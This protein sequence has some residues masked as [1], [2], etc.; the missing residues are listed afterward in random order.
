MTE[1]YEIL[2]NGST[3]TNQTISFKVERN[4]NERSYLNL[5][6]INDPEISVVEGDTINVKV[7]SHS[8]TLT[9][10]FQGKVIKTSKGTQDGDPIL[11]VDGVDLLDRLDELN[12][13]KTYTNETGKTICLD[14]LSE[15]PEITTSNVGD[16]TIPLDFTSRGKTRLE[17]IKDLGFRV[18]WDWY[19]DT[20]NDFHFFERNSID[21]GKTIRL[22]DLENYSYKKDRSSIINRI[23]VLGAEYTIPDPP[24][25]WSD[26]LDDWEGAP[27]TP[28]LVGQM[29]DFPPRL[30]KYAISEQVTSPNTFCYLRRSFSS[31]DLSK[32]WSPKTLNID[33]GFKTEVDV[34]NV[35]LILEEDSSNYFYREITS[36]FDPKGGAWR[37]F[38]VSVGPESSWDSTGNPSWTNINAIKVLLKFVSSTALLFIDRVYFSGARYHGF[39]EDSGPGSSQEEWGVCEPPH[40]VK[41]NI[42]SDSECQ[43]LADKIIEENKEPKEII[44]DTTL[45]PGW[46]DLELGSKV[47]LE[48]PEGTFTKRIL[49]LVHNYQDGDFYTDLTLSKK[50]RTLSEILQEYDQ[51]LKQ[52]SA[53]KEEYKLGA[54]EPNA[55]SRQPCSD[56]CQTECQTDCQISCEA[57]D[58]TCASSYN[59]QSSCQQT[60]QGVKACET[61]G[62][63]QSACQAGHTCEDACQ[64]SCQSTCQTACQDT[65]GCQTVCQE[66]SQTCAS[67]GNCQESCQLTCQGSKACETSGVCQTACQ[68]GHTCEATCQ[69]ACQDTGGCQTECQV[70]CQ[71]ECQPT[72]QTECQDSAGCQTAC[73]NTDQTCGISGNCQVTCQQTCQGSKACE[74]A[75]VCQTACETGHTCQ[76]TCQT[77]C[78]DTVGCQ[79]ECQQTSQTC[80]SSGNCQVACQ[81]TFQG[82]SNYMDKTQVAAATSYNVNATDSGVLAINTTLS[83]VPSDAIQLGAYYLDI[84]GV[85]SGEWARLRFSAEIVKPGGGVRARLSDEFALVDGAPGDT[86]K[87]VYWSFKRVVYLEEIPQNGDYLKLWIYANHGEYKHLDVSVYFYVFRK[88][89]H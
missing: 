73:Q 33:I 63:C 71:V 82:T 17:A 58:Q 12:V 65:E 45:Y 85:N 60:C 59:C 78:Q 32:P 86:N 19:L 13:Y 79:V 88:H 47:T 14:L 4:L 36:E 48:I 83:N 21:S 72:C 56:T 70:T 26:S 77:A 55:P 75:G 53:E 61:E 67:T 15:V 50:T 81:S 3:F 8:D 62:V 68:S 27:A 39:S 43:T 10:I 20:E 28:I 5:K 76:T 84:T 9:Q 52:E 49:K 2:I 1:E 23:V 34:G 54:P 6:L 7:K 87:N 40:V 35:Y 44:E 22:E 80:G 30:G 64:T 69:Y 41:D 25:D 37:T 51:G 16:C 57:S 18:G 31:L 66:T 24:G 46:E 74:T 11:E 42:Y 29:E 89:S 38:S